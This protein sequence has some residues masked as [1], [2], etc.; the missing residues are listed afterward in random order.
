MKPIMSHSDRFERTKFSLNMMPSFS[1]IHKLVIISGAGLD[2]FL[3]LSLDSLRQIIALL[4]VARR[5]PCD[6]PQDQ[7]DFCGH[8]TTK[9]SF[10][11]VSERD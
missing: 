4:E 5:R 6:D 9:L 2:C 1:F 3:P 8:F 11:D 7:N 10:S